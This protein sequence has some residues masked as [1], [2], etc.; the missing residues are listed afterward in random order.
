VLGADRDDGAIG[1]AM[2]NAERAG[3]AR[4]V[5]FRA[6]ALSGSLSAIQDEGGWI[7]TNPPYG[8]RVGAS[9]DLR[10]LYATVGSAIRARPQWRLGVLTSDADLVHHS[11][12]KLA[13]RFSTSNG[14]IPV[15]FFVSEKTGKSAGEIR[16]VTAVRGVDDGDGESAETSGAR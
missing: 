10:N 15:A 7:L 9:G 16:T 13:P 12:L 6:D 1:A 3:V 2:R 5:N 4:D 14:G 11:K 8:I